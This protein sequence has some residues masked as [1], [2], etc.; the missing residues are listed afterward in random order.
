L[1][2]DLKE[3]EKFEETFIKAYKPKHYIPK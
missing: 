2:N 1:E 3:V